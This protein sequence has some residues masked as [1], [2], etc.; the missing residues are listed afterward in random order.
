MTNR[1][2][3]FCYGSTTSLTLIQHTNECVTLSHFP[4]TVNDQKLIAAIMMLVSNL[5]DTQQELD[6]L[7]RNIENQSD[8][9]L[10]PMT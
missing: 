8:I 4:K 9:D 2:C 5:E 3:P 1:R 10:H 6:D 7:K